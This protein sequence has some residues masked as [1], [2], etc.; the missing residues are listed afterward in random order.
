[1]SELYKTEQPAHVGWAEDEIARSVNYRRLA[2][3][4]AG[5]PEMIKT[6]SGSSVV[7][8]VDA[9]DAA[10]AQ[11]AGVVELTMLPRTGF[12]GNATAEWL[13]GQEYPIPVRPN[14]AA[15]CAEGNWV[16]RLSQREYWLLANPN[17]LGKAIS[18]LPTSMTETPAG[19]Y[20]LFCMDSH[21]WLMLTGEHVGEVLSKLSAVDMREQHF[22]LGSI[23]QTS[24]ARVNAVMVR[25]QINGL[26][27]ISILCDV[28]SSDYLWT[29]LMD[30]VQEF[31]GGAV[32]IDVLRSA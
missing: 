4:A 26:P 25:Q 6:A 2:K 14:L 5:E 3:T 16:L 21:A 24:I 32:G 20:P 9:N 7:K 27:A 11:K 8:R 19:C 18:E 10:R 28:A 31:D 29:V 1:M 12:R 15:A 23:A 13:A 30:A 17:D 22:P